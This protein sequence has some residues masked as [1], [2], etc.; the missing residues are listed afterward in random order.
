MWKK[1]DT[2]GQVPT[3]R[4]RST[5][6]QYNNHIYVFGGYHE[7]SCG[8]LFEFN[9]LTKTWKKIITKDGPKQRA[10]HVASIIGDYMYIQGGNER[11]FGPPFD[12]VWKYNMLTNQWTEIPVKNKLKRQFHISGAYQNYFFIQGGCDDLNF[13]NEIHVLKDSEFFTVPVQ[14]DFYPKKLVSHSSIVRFHSLFICGGI[15]DPRATRCENNLYEFNFLFYKWREIQTF[16]KFSPR[17]NAT[18]SIIQNKII[19]FGGYSHN[20]DQLQ[21]DFYLF[22][23]ERNHW[24]ELNFDEKP[25]KRTKHCMVNTEDSLVI[26]SGFGQDGNYFGDLNDMYSLDL[27]LIDLKKNIF[28]S[29]EKCIYNDILFEYLNSE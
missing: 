21:N 2:I 19:L 14:G 9:L 23:F 20:Y 8:E 15:E 18:M 22:D 16:S 6:C 27:G 1:I 11:S 24:S 17:C 10:G 13:Y 3:P 4:R 25:T 28:K 5:M 12:D 29:I 26:F 7:T